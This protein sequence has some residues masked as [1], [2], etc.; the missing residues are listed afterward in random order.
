MLL[1]IVKGSR[2]AA[3]AAAEAHSVSFWFEAEGRYN[4][5]Y[6]CAP[7]YHSSK[8]YAWFDEPA[9]APYPD[10]TLLFFTERTDR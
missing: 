10:G 6:L 2:E 5:I 9:K 7:S 8:I 3:F 1:L 4:E